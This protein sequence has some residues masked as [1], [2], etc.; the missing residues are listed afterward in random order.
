LEHLLDRT[1]AP[2]LPS[3]PALSQHPPA[4]FPTP[5]AK[6]TTRS[7]SRAYHPFPRTWRLN[8]AQPYLAGQVPSLQHR[9][10]LFLAYAAPTSPFSSAYHLNNAPP[11]SST[12]LPPH[13]HPPALFQQP[14]ILF[15]MPTASTTPHRSFSRAYRLD[16]HQPLFFQDLP[17]QQR[18]ASLFHTLD[19]SATHCERL[20]PQV[21]R[22][23][24][25]VLG[26]GEA[27]R[28]RRPGCSTVQG[29]MGKNMVSREGAPV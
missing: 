25:R 5:T 23:W 7:F 10:A 24:V 12:R 21:T 16:K 15:L 8:N 27:E 1:E 2:P 11:L 22:P 29:R 3:H 19:A 4:L 26:G 13:Q 14:G 28:R 17:P 6:T 20:Q 9:T 18:V